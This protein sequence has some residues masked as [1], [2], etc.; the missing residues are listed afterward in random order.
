MAETKFDFIILFS[1]IIMR[2]KGENSTVLKHKKTI[3]QEWD[4]QHHKLIAIK[5]IVESLVASGDNID[6]PYL[7]NDYQKPGSILCAL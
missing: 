5:I 2:L 1:S 3:R 7:L 4:L 6:A